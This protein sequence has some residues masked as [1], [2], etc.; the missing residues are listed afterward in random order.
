[1]PATLYTQRSK[2]EWTI[3]AEA[4]KGRIDRTLRKLIPVRELYYDRST[5]GFYV[6]I[7]NAND[8]QH[9]SRQGPYYYRDLSGLARMLNMFHMK[10]GLDIPSV[11]CIDRL[12]NEYP[13]KTLPAS[14]RFN[15]LTL[16]HS[17]MIRQLENAGIKCTLPNETLQPARAPVTETVTDEYQE[18]TDE[19]EA[20]IDKMM[21][22]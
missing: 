12:G 3:S 19:E 13:E 2:T 16:A 20:L 4:L 17:D 1:M 18:A 8:P 7:I 14:L 6:R 5:G 9:M 21:E 15:V 22:E 11:T 10:N